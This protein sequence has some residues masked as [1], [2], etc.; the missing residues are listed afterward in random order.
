[1]IHW[2]PTT[3]ADDWKRLADRLNA[4]GRQ[5]Q[6]AGMRTAYHNHDFELQPVDGQLPLE[7]L[8]AGTDPALV[9]FELD[10][11]W[12][13]H[14]GHDPLDWFGRHPGR[15]ALL[16]LKDSKGAPQ[17][18]M[19]SVGSGRIDW[20]RVLAARPKAGVKHVFV[21]HDNPTDPWESIGASIA[22]LKKL[23]VPAA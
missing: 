20:P 3:R 17:H 18:E 6:A 2:C 1:M 19:T 22:Y 9:D 14:A 21:E 11:Y 8:V 7:L 16:H 23:Q 15:F 4:T 10:C 5:T 13:T 12:V